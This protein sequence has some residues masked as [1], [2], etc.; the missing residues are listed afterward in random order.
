MQLENAQACPLC[1]RRLPAISAGQPPGTR[2]CERC[3]SIV[4]R[5]FAGSATQTKRSNTQAALDVRFPATRSGVV[6][7]STNSDEGLPTGGPESDFESSLAFDARDEFVSGPIDAEEPHGEHQTLDRDPDANAIADPAFIE[8]VT[9]GASPLNG[10]D[11]EPQPETFADFRSESTALAEQPAELVT[12]GTAADPAQSPLVKWDYAH[13]EWP[14]LVG[15]STK[16]PFGKL[17]AALVVIAVLTCA[18]VMY[19]LIRQTSAQQQPPRIAPDAAAKQRTPANAEPAPSQASQVPAAT[20]ANHDSAIGKAPANEAG[21]VE[22]K[23][24]G[25][26]AF[27]LQAASFPTQSG[28]D[29]FAERLRRAGVPSYVVAS[30]LARRGKWF[31][32]RVGRFSAA[33]AAQKFAA[34]AQRRAKAAGFSLQLIVCQYEQP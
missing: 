27:S 34:E 31:R 20:Q 14:V 29:E 33:D 26:G 30:D 11:S 6:V 21:A 2:L 3:Q 25:Q 17:R 24:D 16:R 1:R 28:A 19:Y 8:T 5:A 4:E 18:A 9:T 7:P 23:T 10:Q 22:V 13:D 32:V 12:V 15:P